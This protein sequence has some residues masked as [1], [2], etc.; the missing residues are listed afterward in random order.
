MNDKKQL[1]LDAMGVIFMNRDDFEEVYLPQLKEKHDFDIGKA[2]DLY[3][4]KLTLG[5]LTSAE[6][7]RE[8]GISPSL[9]FVK[10]LR[11]DP[12]FAWFA[13]KT[14]NFY[15][16]SVLSNDAIEWSR[17]LR[18]N[19][20]LDRFVQN[21]FVSGELGYRKPDRRAYL[22]VMKRLNA[23]P[24][25]CIL[26][27]NREVNL[28]SAK[29]LG[30]KTVHFDR[31]LGSGQ[32]RNF[33]GLLSEVMQNLEVNLDSAKKLGWKTVHFDGTPGNSKVRNF[34]RLLRKAM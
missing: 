28:D 27:D 31:T 11:I 3:Y 10:K 33:G 7:F 20:H 6:F 16:L 2:R 26:V 15:C 4:G 9:E 14:G 30:W 19:Y 5:K 18:E 32:V 29:K 25:D 1:I 12:G 17:L 34:G 13:E 21:Y 23:K 22:E 24:C 8:L